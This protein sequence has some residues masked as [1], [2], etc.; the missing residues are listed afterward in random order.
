MSSPTISIKSAYII[1]P[2]EVNK[3]TGALA[4][5][6]GMIYTGGIQWSAAFDW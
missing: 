3:K 5:A 2:F 6:K 1:H 4:P